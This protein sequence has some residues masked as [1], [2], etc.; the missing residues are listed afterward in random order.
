M[1]ITKIH[2]CFILR[3]C[4]DGPGRSVC[5]RCQAVIDS[6]RLSC[7][8]WSPR[9]IMEPLAANDY[10]LPFPEY[11]PG[12]E[13]DA[14]QE[15]HAECVV[16]APAAAVAP[17]AQRPRLFEA[18]V[19]PFKPEECKIQGG[20]PYKS[21]IQMIQ[22]ATTVQ[23]IVEIPV[24]AGSRDNAFGCTR[25]ATCRY[26]ACT[27]QESQRHVLFHHEDPNTRGLK[28]SCVPECVGVEYSVGDAA[29]I[30]RARRAAH[31]Q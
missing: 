25:G 15:A 9:K 2:S 29:P 20:G 6:K 28:R 16:P 17:V 7:P 12:N 5:P 19:T 3:M 23:R 21:L 18:V 4:I 31:L 8:G 24:N 14:P 1:H 11:L 13:P 10:H 22:G 30:K 26:V 27:N